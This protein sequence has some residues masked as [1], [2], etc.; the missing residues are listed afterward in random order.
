MR[1]KCGKFFGFSFKKFFDKRIEKKI[2]KFE[3][4]SEKVNQHNGY[5]FYPV[6]WPV[7]TSEGECVWLEPVFRKC[8]YRV[9]EFDPD[10]LMIASPMLYRIDVSEIGKYFLVEA[11]IPENA[12]RRYIFDFNPEHICLVL[13]TLKVLGI[14]LGGISILY[15]IVSLGALLLT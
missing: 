4:I 3:K 8:G 11:D 12:H 6:L 7:R 9:N 15:A 14:L 13:G 1:F 2:L 5:F 10:P